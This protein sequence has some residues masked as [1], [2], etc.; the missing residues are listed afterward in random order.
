MASWPDL[1]SS[2]HHGGYKRSLA[3]Y[4]H[5]KRLEGGEK[6]KRLKVKAAILL[7]LVMT[8]AASVTVFASTTNPMD[9]IDLAGA[10]GDG[11]G[12]IVSQIGGILLV[13]LPAGLGLVGLF[14][15][16]RW[17]IGFIK[18]LGKG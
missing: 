17:G 9:D 4:V 2:L 16:I 11:F 12:N 1:Y 10:M 5:E 7:A 6:M 14:I 13:V 8:V 3:Y 15:A 18:G